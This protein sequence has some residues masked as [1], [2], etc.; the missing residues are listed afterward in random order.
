MKDE[1][2]KNKQQQPMAP[3]QAQNYQQECLD[4]GDDQDSQHQQSVMN[5]DG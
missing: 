5:T 1:A 3:G 2:H 4:D